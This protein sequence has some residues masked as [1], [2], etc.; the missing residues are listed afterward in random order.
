MKITKIVFVLILLA[1]I[2][3]ACLNTETGTQTFGEI[4]N[5]LINPINIDEVRRNV[6]INDNDVLNFMLEKHGLFDSNILLGIPLE[7]TNGE[8]NKGNISNDCERYPIEY[9]FKI[10]DN[11]TGNEL[12]EYITINSN[13]GDIFELGKEYYVFPSHNN[14][15]L[16]DTHHISSF[17]QVISRELFT[18]DDVYKIRQMV[19]KNKNVFQATQTVIEN[20]SLSRNFIDNVDLVISV[21]VTD[22]WEEFRSNTIFDIAYELNE[23]IYVSEDRYKEIFMFNV[24][25]LMRINSDVKIGETYMIMQNAVNDGVPGEYFFM[26][27]ARNGVVI[28]EDSDDYTRYKEEFTTLHSKQKNNE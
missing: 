7:I 27:A 14:S 8:W 28:S 15:T 4:E 17:P 16:W 25:E 23:I 5:V 20:A 2:L 11:L 21:T 26:P 3:P 10:V 6:G 19:D 22:K 9:L 12:P 1:F 18:N 24:G 13:L